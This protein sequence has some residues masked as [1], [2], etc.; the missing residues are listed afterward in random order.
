MVRYCWPSAATSWLA[1]SGSSLTGVSTIAIG[2]GKQSTEF[3]ES[4]LRE[5]VEW[6]ERNRKESFTED[7]GGS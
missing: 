3:E 1:R 6:Y 5:N 4:L 2:S 7:G